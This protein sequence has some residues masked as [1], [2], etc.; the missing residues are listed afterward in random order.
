M[1]HVGQITKQTLL[2]HLLGQFAA[3]PRIIHDAALDLIQLGQKVGLF[4]SPILIVIPLQL[5][6]NNRRTLNDDRPIL[7][8]NSREIL[9]VTRVGKPLVE[10]S[11]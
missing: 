7:S 3:Q 10:Q 4:P 1:K 9:N 6:T 8:A 11:D 5:I 2:K